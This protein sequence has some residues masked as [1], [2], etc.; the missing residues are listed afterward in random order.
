MYSYNFAGAFS[1]IE[2]V[3]NVGN[4]YLSVK[5]FWNLAKESDPK[6]LE[7]VIYTAVDI[8]RISSIMMQPFCPRQA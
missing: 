5:E 7:E 8:M 4:T 2:K 6:H 3:V 1:N